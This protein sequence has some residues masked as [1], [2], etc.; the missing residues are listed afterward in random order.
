MYRAMQYL[1]LSINETEAI[2]NCLEKALRTLVAVR[3]RGEPPVFPRE[4]AITNNGKES[5]VAGAIG[6]AGTSR[7]RSS[8]SSDLTRRSSRTW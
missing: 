7:G 8:G 6:G 5:I 2:W 1:V 3:D 4:K